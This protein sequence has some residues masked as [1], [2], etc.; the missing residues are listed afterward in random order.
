MPPLQVIIVGGGLAGCLLGN[1]LHNNGIAV[2]VY[3]RFRAC[4]SEQHT[5]KIVN[6]FSQSLPSYSRS[7]AINRV[8]LRNLLSEP[9][10]KT[11]RMR[12]GKKFTRYEVLESER[13]R[14]HFSDG[15]IDECDILVGA[16]SSGSVLNKQGGR[17][18][19]V[20]IDT[21]WCFLSKGSLPISALKR[22]PP[23]LRKGP[24]SPSQRAA[25][26]FMPESFYW[27]LNIE[28][29]YGQWQDVSESPDKLKFCLEFAKVWPP[30]LSPII[31][32]WCGGGDR[33]GSWCSCSGT[34][35]KQEACE[36]LEEGMAAPE[37]SK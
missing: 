14:A 7:W 3:E 8:V 10:E 16:D 37:P 6:K 25:R 23:Q 34:K 17:N 36:G 33:A 2:T 12:Y 20:P 5:A 4:L 19:I 22:L 29:S 24:V 27:G 30:E 15:S 26:S 32:D 21:H 11:G 18:N 28:K 9:L 35:S 1:G 13:V 31:V